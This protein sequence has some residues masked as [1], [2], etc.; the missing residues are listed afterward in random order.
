MRIHVLVEN[1]SKPG[2]P[3]G[4][5]GLSLYVEANGYT[6][7]FDTGQ[8]NMFVRNAEIMG[9]DL[10]KVSSAVISHGHYD[11]GGGL[12]TF[13]GVNRHAPV[14]VHRRA[15][16]QH[17]SLRSD[18]NYTDI[19]LDPELMT[20]IR[21]VLTNG[22]TEISKGA[23]LFCDVKKEYP[24]PQNNR[25]LFIKMGNDLLPDDF[26][27]EQNLLIWENDKTVLIAGCAHRGIA[28]IVTKAKKI[29]GRYPDV[30]VGGFHLH[31]RSEDEEDP[32]EVRCLAKTLLET[33]SLY[34][35]CHCTGT[36][37]YEQM[38]TIIGDRIKTMTTGTVLEL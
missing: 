19:G 20:D 2:G 37:A 17:L 22:N 6:I 31:G 27:H 32:S 24:V 4:E 10:S 34:F 18:G 5:H 11:H 12:K 8:G 36:T 3:T 9:I 23:L 13:L 28:N 25:N 26:K 14:Y 21:V 30:V 16:E 35:T 1:T 33:G 29:I 7:L 38:K 15:F